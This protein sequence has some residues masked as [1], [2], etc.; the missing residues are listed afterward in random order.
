MTIALNDFDVS[1]VAF[2]AAFHCYRSSHFLLPN[3]FVLDTNFDFHSNCYYFHQIDY[4]YQIPSAWLLQPPPPLPLD[5]WNMSSIDLPDVY[6]FFLI[7]C[8][9]VTNNRL[10]HSLSVHCVVVVLWSLQLYMQIEGILKQL[11]L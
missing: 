8:P 10:R 7:F 11:P 3:A 5:R 4:R 1:A 6:G 9:L 2:D